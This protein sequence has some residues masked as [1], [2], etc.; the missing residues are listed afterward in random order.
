MSDFA[1]LRTELA[2]ALAERFA[3]LSKFFGSIANPEDAGFVLETMVAQDHEAFSKL[4]DRLPLPEPP[5]EWPK[6]GKC[7]WLSEIVEQTL[8]N[9]EDLQV[10]KGWALREELT[11]EERL[12]LYLVS[13]T[14]DRA[15]DPLT[16]T[17]NPDGR[18]I[19]SEGFC[20]EAL[21][22]AGLVEEVQWKV[23]AVVKIPGKPIRV[24]I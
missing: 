1:K 8:K 19:V 17:V 12:Q 16:T 10:L 15:L 22:A 13:R 3:A 11:R 2:P 14:C 4:V 6:L 9:P 5:P 7:I 20:L 23:E 21:K 24:C 18:H